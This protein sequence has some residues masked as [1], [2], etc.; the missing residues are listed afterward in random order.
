[1]GTLC[2]FNIFIII[3]T[4]ILPHLGTKQIISPCPIMQCDFWHTPVYL[5]TSMA[6]ISR[7]LGLVDPDCTAVSYTGFWQLSAMLY[8]CI[9]QR[10][11][12]ARPTEAVE[13]RRAIKKKK[14]Q[15]W[16]Q[17]QKQ[18]AIHLRPQGEQ[19]AELLIAKPKPAHKNSR[20]MDSVQKPRRGL[21]KCATSKLFR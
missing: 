18:E 20:K 12:Q 7:G 13:A 6:K 16:P 19:D 5:C 15:V 17:L 11:N 2:P 1:M 8:V 10:A 3:F 4:V 9:T 14:K 21:L